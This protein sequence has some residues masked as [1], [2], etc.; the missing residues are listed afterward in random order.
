MMI[1]IA[2]RQRI[3]PMSQLAFYIATAHYISFFSGTMLQT[4]TKL[5]WSPCRSVSCPATHNCIQSPGIATVPHTGHKKVLVT[6]AAGFIGSHVVSSLIDRGDEVIILDEMND[7]DEL[8]YKQGNLKVLHE[9][10]KEVVRLTDKRGEDVLTFYDGSVNNHSLMIDIFE[11]HTPKWICHLEEKAG[12]ALIVEPPLHVRANVEG[13][14]NLLE[15]SR[16]Y[17][18]TNVV[19]ISSPS[20]CGDI[21]SVH[22]E[23]VHDNEPI[24]PYAATKRSAELISYTY[25]KL[26]GLRVTNMRFSSLVPDK[27]G[28]GTSNCTSIDDVVARIQHAIDR[29]YPFQNFHLGGG[30]GLHSRR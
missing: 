14:A 4:S 8:K 16:M 17:N 12:G 30:Q 1:A 2:P 23:M 6:G 10:A 27:Y 24:S 18:A 13:T 25:Q 21:H 11:R 3:T 9:K 20:V 22:S 26:F 5:P 7:S 19:I 29:S 28:D 15:Y